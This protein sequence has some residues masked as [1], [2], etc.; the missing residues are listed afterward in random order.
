M[1][2]RTSLALLAVGAPLL[3]SGCG[4][5]TTDRTVSGAGIG[6]ATGAV[7]GAVYAMTPVGGALLGGAIGGA[8]GALTDPQSSRSRQAGLA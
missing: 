7:V 1:L 5:N 4:T 2:S 3:L 8:A 6:A